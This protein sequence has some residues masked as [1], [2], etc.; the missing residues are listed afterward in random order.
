MNF[1]RLYSKVFE[2]RISPHYERE[3]SEKT[4]EIMRETNSK[5]ARINEENIK[6]DKYCFAPSNI[7]PA[8]RKHFAIATLGD[9][10]YIHGGT[11]SKVVF[12]DLV[13][14]NTIKKEWNCYQFDKGIP[15]CRH[16]MASH[17]NELFFFSP[18][19]KSINLQLIR[20]RN[21]RIFD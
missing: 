10:I 19:K 3:K 14:F 9:T 18:Q 16:Q 8:K 13:A 1:E 12:S 2:L 7:Q 4:E 15:I 21:R 11:D 17:D 6:A 20:I 5:T